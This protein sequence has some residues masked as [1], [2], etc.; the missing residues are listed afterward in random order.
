MQVGGVVVRAAPASA[1]GTI[2]PN[3]DG[4]W[5]P[6]PNTQPVELQRDA[7]TPV[8]TGHVQVALS[9][10]GA[11]A[12]KI[13]IQAAHRDL[14]GRLVYAKPE[15]VLLPEQPGPIRP[16]G[17]M[18]RVISAFRGK[19]LS[20]LGALI[21][22]SKDCRLDKDESSFKIRIDVPG[23]LHT[24]SPELTARAKGQPLHNSPMTLTDVEGDFAPP[25]SRSPGRSAR[26]RFRPERSPGRDLPSRSEQRPDPLP[27]QE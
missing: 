11:S 25:W 8:A 21:D 12:R 5:P 3:S 7:R 23:K 22:P 1:V 27:R 6:L 18:A 26:F 14:R 19:S 13:L 4:V 17:D 24:L 10:Q 20:M 2:N 15:E 16:P 9:G